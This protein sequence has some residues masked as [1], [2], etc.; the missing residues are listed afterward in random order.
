MENLAFFEDF[1]ILKCK[2]TL[3]DLELWR[4]T[5]QSKNLTYEDIAALSAIPK[6]TVTNIF[7]GYVK[8]PRIDTVQAIEKALGITSD[9]SSERGAL[10]SGQQKI[11]EIFDEIGRR[12]G[13][14]GQQNYIALGENLLKIENK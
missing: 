10:T 14:N 4:K 3:M 1:I 2:E 12:Y 7:C 6:K 11:L 5:K 8:T 9:N 13:E